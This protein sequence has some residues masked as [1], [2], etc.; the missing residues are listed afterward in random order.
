METE[1]VAATLPTPA[2]PRIARDA[3]GRFLRGSV[4]NPGGRPRGL[5]ALRERLEPLSWEFVEAV[6]KLAKTAKSERVR[7]EAWKV[8]LAYSVGQPA[9]SLE[10]SAAEGSGVEITLKALR[11]MADGILPTRDGASGS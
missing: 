8:L 9:N 11:E 5:A 10:L 7:L 1:E 2:A 4:P 3:R 6:I